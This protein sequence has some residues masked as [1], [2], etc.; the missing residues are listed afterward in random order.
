MIDV[1]Q[2]EQAIASALT[3]L[4]R[5]SGYDRFAY[6][7]TKGPEVR[8]FNSYPAQ[9]QDLYLRNDYSRIDPVVTE[10]KR[11]LAMFSWSSDDWPSGGSSQVRQFREEAI[12]HGI[13]HG[14]TIPVKGSF[15]ST[16]MLTLAS[17]TKVNDDSGFHDPQIALQVVMAVHYRLEIVSAKTVLNP[18][19]LLSPRET[20]CVAWALKGRST[21]ETAMLTGI[22][23]RTV[24]HYLDNARRKLNAK[25]LPQLIGMVKD[26]GLM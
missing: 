21:P 14:V 7:Q 4:A 26:R 24:Q 19:T 9:W 22:N 18:K 10:A 5:A 23:P 13:S 17:S 2:D 1:A 20:M 11:K 6:L 3:N 15:G 12:D 16:M 8:T 25:T